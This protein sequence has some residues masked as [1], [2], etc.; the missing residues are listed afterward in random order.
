MTDGT[1]PQF[2]GKGGVAQPGKPGPTQAVPTWAKVMC[3]FLTAGEIAR[4][5]NNLVV[6]AGVQPPAPTAQSCKGPQCM[7]FVE[8]KNADGTVSGGCAPV[9]QVGLLNHLTFLVARFIAAAEAGAAAEAA[10]AERRAREA[11]GETTPTVAPA[12]MLVAPS[13][14]PAA[15]AVVVAESMEPV[16]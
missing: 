14:E 1:V 15:P 2:P 16:R 5:S 9:M 3:P 12:L 11:A 10:E 8:A 6:Q 4:V 13:T 7:L